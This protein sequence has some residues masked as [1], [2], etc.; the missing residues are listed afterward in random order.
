MGRNGLNWLVLGMDS[1]GA[2]RYG[3]LRQKRMVAEQ[4]VGGGES[5][6]VAESERTVKLGID[7][8]SFGQAEAESRVMNGSAE[9]S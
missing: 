7:K 2:Y 5:R 4:I 9:V 1:S 6:V 8:D 3:G